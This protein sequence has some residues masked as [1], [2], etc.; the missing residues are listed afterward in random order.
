MSKCVNCFSTTDN[1]KTIKCAT[2]GAEMHPGCAQKCDCGKPVCDDCMIKDKQ[3]IDCKPKPDELPS[4]IR[5]SHIE[6]YKKCPYAFYLEVIKEL[7]NQHTIYTQMGIDLHELF[8]KHSKLTNTGYEDIMAE[9]MPFLNAY[10]DEWYEKGNELLTANFRLTM[11]ERAQNSIRG[12]IKLRGELPKPYITEEKIIFSIS[13]ELPSI[14]ITMDRIDECSDGSLDIGDYKTGKV[15]T[16]KKLTTDLQVPLYI[17]AVKNHFKKRVNKFSLYYVSEDKLRVYHRI[18][19][20]KYVCTVGKK[21]Y[22]ISIQEAIR[23]VKILFGRIKQR[24]YNIPRDLKEYTCSICHFYNTNC[25]GSV[26][27]RWQQVNGGKTC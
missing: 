11:L 23:E 1:S 7:G 15:M 20:D 13:D 17:Y 27:G 19:D 4:V 2:C 26:D 24:N 18:D 14:S 12:F 5:R 25:E 16:G 6:L 21:E 22:V 3:C 8:D 10:P 9:F